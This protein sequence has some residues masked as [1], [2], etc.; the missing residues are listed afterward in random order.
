[1]LIVSDD[2]HMSSEYL[3]IK[4]RRISSLASV[5][6]VHEMC[7]SIFGHWCNTHSF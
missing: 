3:F 6:M 4:Q 2:R 7:L 1:V 5:K